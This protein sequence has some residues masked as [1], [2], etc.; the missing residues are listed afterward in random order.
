MLIMISGAPIK[1]IKSITTD[2]FLKERTDTNSKRYVAYSFTQGLRYTMDHIA[3]D[4]VQA[5][6]ANRSFNTGRQP[7]NSVNQ[8]PISNLLEAVNVTRRQLDLEFDRAKNGQFPWNEIESVLGTGDVIYDLP[9]RRL[10]VR[11]ESEEFMEQWVDTIESAIDSSI[12][13]EWIEP[14]F[15]AVLESSEPGDSDAKKNL[16]NLHD[17]FYYKPK[18]RVQADFD[19]MDWQMRTL[20]LESV[21]SYQGF[22]DRP[23]P[24]LTSR[25]SGKKYDWTPRKIEK[26]L[27][28]YFDPESEYSGVIRTSDFAGLWRRKYSREFTS[29][30]EFVWEEDQEWVQA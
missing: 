11:F 27:M 8:S 17:S 20:D 9:V 22:I 2:Q 10:V 19:G 28:N 16:K 29:T 1:A 23:Q 26:Y 21:W 7:I 30:K 13:T 25:K 6:D 15:F 3:P 18:F 24:I 4:Q 12:P 5:L 14:P